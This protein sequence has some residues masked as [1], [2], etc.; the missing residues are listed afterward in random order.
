MK[1]WGFRMWKWGQQGSMGWGWGM[2]ELFPSFTQTTYFFCLWFWTLL[3]L[4]LPFL[5]VLSTWIVTGRIDA[6][7]PILWHLMQRV[8]SMEKTL[9]LGKIEG[10]RREQHMMRWLHGIIDST[11]MSLSKLREDG[12]GEGSLACCSPQGCKVRHDWATE[13]HCFIGATVFLS[14]VLLKK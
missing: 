10:R 13:Q 11:D 9:M 5:P 8:D 12:E 6:E 2:F 4:C 3:L 1:Y 7:A 14:E